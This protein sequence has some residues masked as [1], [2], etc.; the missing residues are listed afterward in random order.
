[1]W[2]GVL[3]CP[4]EFTAALLHC[5]FTAHISRWVERIGSL[6]RS[7]VVGVKEIESSVLRELCAKDAVSLIYHT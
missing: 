4:Y 7:A 3:M 1:M 6:S 2:G 5:C